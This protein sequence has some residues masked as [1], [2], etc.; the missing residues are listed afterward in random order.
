[1]V[2]RAIRG[3]SASLGASGLRTSHKVMVGAA[4]A[5]RSIRRL[6]G[7]RGLPIIGVIAFSPDKTIEYSQ[8]S[9]RIIFKEKH[10]RPHIDLD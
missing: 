4:N 10:L 1:M 2:I 6:T 8:Q 3:K 7:N 9:G 5:S